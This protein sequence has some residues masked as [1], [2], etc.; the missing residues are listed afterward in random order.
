MVPL[1]SGKINKTQDYKLEIDVND[2][3]KEKQ[4]NTQLGMR[5]K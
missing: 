4:D 1:E 3:V 2:K 5:L